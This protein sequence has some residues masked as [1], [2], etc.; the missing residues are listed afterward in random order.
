MSS[1]IETTLKTS[2]RH[3]WSRDEVRGIFNEPLLNLIAEAQQLHSQHHKPREVQLCQLISIKT[4]VC[5]NTGVWAPIR[6]GLWL[7]PI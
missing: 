3:D 2:L 5:G 1:T 6:V 7:R 4:G